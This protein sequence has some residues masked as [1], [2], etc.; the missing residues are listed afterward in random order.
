MRLSLVYFNV[1]TMVFIEKITK[2]VRN[3]PYDKISQQIFNK[4]VESTLY[5]VIYY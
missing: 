5:G 1:S 3:S 2:S 4:T